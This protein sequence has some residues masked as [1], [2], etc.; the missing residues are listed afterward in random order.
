MSLHIHLLHWN[1][2]QQLMIP[3]QFDPNHRN[4]APELM[5]YD[6][7]LYQQ[8][9]RHPPEFADKHRQD[10]ETNKHI[11][12]VNQLDNLAAFYLLVRVSCRYDITV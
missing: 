3:G 12:E 6:S 11:S 5:S 10:I 4:N 7:P 9:E 8:H 1:K 2:L